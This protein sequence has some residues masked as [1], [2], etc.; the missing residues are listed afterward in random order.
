MGKNSGYTL[1]EVLIS[2]AIVASTILFAAQVADM[3][4]KE[5]DEFQK[6]QSFAL[7]RQELMN[8]AFDPDKLEIILQHP[9]NYSAGTANGTQAYFDPA[10]L[11]TDPRCAAT[12]RPINFYNFSVSNLAQDE[13]ASANAQGQHPIKLATGFNASGNPTGFFSQATPVGGPGGWDSKLSAISTVSR[14]IGASADATR[15]FNSKGASCTGFSTVAP[16]ECRFQYQVKFTPLC[17]AA[18]RGYN[19]KFELIDSKLAI[20]TNVL[21]NYSFEIKKPIPIAPAPAILQLSFQTNTGCVITGDNRVKCWGSNHAGMLGRAMPAGGFNRNPEYVVHPGT[22]PGD[23]DPFTGVHKIVNGNDTMCVK[24]NPS[25]AGPGVFYA[26]CWGE[27]F[28]A[29]LGVGVLPGSQGGLPILTTFGTGDLRNTET[30]IRPVASVAYSEG[31]EGCAVAGSYLCNIWDVE[32]IFGLEHGGCA[33]TTT[34]GILCWG[35]LYQTRVIAKQMK[36]M[37]TGAATFPRVVG[38]PT[39]PLDP[40]YYTYN[41]GTL[42][43]P[44]AP[45]PAWPATP[46]PSPDKRVLMYETW[47]FDY[48]VLPLPYP[49][50]SE[51]WG[52]LFSVVQRIDSFT[53]AEIKGTDGAR[54]GLNKNWYLIGQTEGVDT[55]SLPPEYVAGDTKFFAG[56]IGQC[57]LITAG[58]RAGQAMCWGL[59]SGGELGTTFNSAVVMSDRFFLPALGS[60]YTNLALAHVDLIPK[61]Q[62]IVHVAADGNEALCATLKNT[63]PENGKAVCM[64]NDLTWGQKGYLGQGPTIGDYRQPPGYVLGPGS[65]PLENIKYVNA[66]RTSMCAL[67]YSN[68]VFCW[69]ANDV[70]QLGNG[71]VAANS[72]IAVKALLP[73]PAKSVEVGFRGACAIGQSDRVYCWGLNDK[74]QLGPG[75]VGGFSNL[76]VEVT[77]L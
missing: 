29:G 32:D 2:I 10:I 44:A 40:K 41:T 24:Y 9:E 62:N 26:K 22:V 21:K 20:A 39:T 64:G 73:E 4:S 68:E 67:T 37:G 58:A 45:L 16:N 57:F 31:G 6:V 7:N 42:P 11:L 65:V 35:E 25:W 46:D 19:L 14:P 55:A 76:P 3:G 27:N 36:I 12:E 8:I 43:A 17:G 52:W 61:L 30:G 63:A 1:I 60:Q 66:G 69:G 75:F 38:A 47:G 33:T 50:G 48:S 59:N 28:N 54:D 71:S 18:G 51:D 77:G 23:N 74:G 72:N 70:G 49:A 15:G 56:P 5:V 34:H 13:A 53:N